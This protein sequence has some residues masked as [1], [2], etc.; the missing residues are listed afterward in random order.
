MSPLLA[1]LL[2]IIQGITEFLP[3]SSFGHL[4]TVEKLFGAERQAGVLFEVMLHTG[5]LAAIFIVFW[6]DLKRIGEELLGMAMDLAGNLNLYIHNRRTGE[7]LHYARIV[8]GT[9]RKFAALILVSSVPT[10]VLGCKGGCFT[11]ASG[12]LF[13][14]HRDFPAG[15]RSG[16]GRHEQDPQG[17]RVRQCH[18]DGDLPGTECISRDFQRRYDHLCRT[19]LR[20]EP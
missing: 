17:S 3:V 11:T 2:G 18:V 13:F 1:I 15:N 8:Y 6:S 9:Y 19:S 14:D 7:H 12:D 10:A 20:A 4:A 5:T 16:S